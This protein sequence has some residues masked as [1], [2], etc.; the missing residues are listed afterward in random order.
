MSTIFRGWW[1][2]GKP[3]VVVHN[4]MKV[5]AVH[6][7]HPQCDEKTNPPY[8]WGKECA[9]TSVLALSMLAEACGSFG[10]AAE[11]AAKFAAEVLAP[12]RIG[13]NF[14]MHCD[15]VK[16]WLFSVMSEELFPIFLPGKEP[17]N[18]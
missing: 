8:M 12:L 5:H 7:R 13:D 9:A 4:L 6:L 10:I 15:A 18:G 11:Y 1:N 16:D 17:S 3:Y 14:A 2:G